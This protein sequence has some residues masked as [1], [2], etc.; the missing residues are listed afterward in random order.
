LL[1]EPVSIVLGTLGGYL[2]LRTMKR[3]EAESNAG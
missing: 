1:M 2:R 3:P